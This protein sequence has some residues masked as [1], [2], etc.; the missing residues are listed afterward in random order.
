MVGFGNVPHIK[1]FVH[2]IHTQ[3]VTGTQNGAA[4]RV[5]RTANAVIAG[6]LQNADAALG[7][8][9]KLAGTQKSVVVVDAGTAELYFF[10]VDADTGLR[11]P[12]K[13]TNT[14]LDFFRV[15]AAAK[16]RAVQIRM[17]C[18]PQLC[19]GDFHFSR[20]AL[21]DQR[22]T[23]VDFHGGSGRGVG[24]H[25]NDSGRNGLCCDADIADMLFR[26]DN[27]VYGSVNAGAGIPTVVGFQAVVN[28]YFQMVGACLNSIADIYREL[29]VA[30]GVAGKFLFVHI[31]GGAAV[32]TL[33]NQCDVLPDLFGCDFKILFVQVSSTGEIA[34]VRAVQAFAPGFGNHSIVGQMYRFCLIGLVIEAKPP[35]LHKVICH[36]PVSSL[37]NLADPHIIFIILYLILLR[38]VGNEQTVLKFV[39]KMLQFK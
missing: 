31:N 23:I 10:A 7:G 4:C 5:M 11:T 33:K 32:D 38:N 26:S 21:G 20:Y 15:C 22:F 24:C 35:V 17:F 36:V 1:G 34:G 18:I 37:K 27:K 8:G 16:H 28:V 6:L 13:L 39:S 19:M 9:V 14:K 29:C 3:A 12:C 25:G 2:H 30:V